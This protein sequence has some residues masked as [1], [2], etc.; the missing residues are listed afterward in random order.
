MLFFARNRR[1]KAG[2]RLH[3]ISPH[4]D[5]HL[6]SYGEMRID[7]K[8]AQLVEVD[9]TIEEPWLWKALA[10]GTVLDADVVRKIKKIKGV[11]LQDYWEG[12]LNLSCRNGYQLKPNQTQRNAKPMQI[13]KDLNT[14][15]NFKFAVD[16]DQLAFFKRD[17]VC[18]PRISEDAA[19]PLLVYRGPLVLIRESPGPD[20]TEGWALFCANDLAYNQSFYGYSGA[21]HPEGELLVKYLQLFVHSQLWLHYALL[22]SAKLGFERPNVYKTDLDRCLFFPLERLTEAQKKQVKQLSDRLISEDSTVFA[23][24]D[25]FFGKLYGLNHLDIEVIAD[26]LKVREPNDELGIRASQVPTKPECLLF[27]RRIESILAPLFKALGK[28][29]EVT[30]W[31]TSED[32]E[33]PFLMLMLSVKGQKPGDPQEIFQSDVLPLAN[34]TGATCI[35]KEVE[36]GL[37]VGLLRQYR[38]W[39][40]SRARMLC[41][42]I[43]RQHMAIFED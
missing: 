7:S 18:W 25:S 30:I 23:N 40:P 16:T 2:H 38:Y 26:T 20:R 3:F 43:I 22:T 11:P 6:N 14:T 10:V 42:E 8:S 21:G 5:Y 19:D 34:E 24:I 12:L 27:I 4:T 37:L 32:I 28:Q 41:A 39:T 31:K 33:S 9:E 1:P 13:L 17:K 36:R 35:F 15:N 29:P